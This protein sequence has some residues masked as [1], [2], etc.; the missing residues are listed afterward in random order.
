M[1]HNFLFVG[2]PSIP[3]KSTALLLPVFYQHIDPPSHRRTKQ[4]FKSVKICARTWKLCASQRKKERKKEREREAFVGFRFM[5][6]T[7]TC[8]GLGKEKK[9]EN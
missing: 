9:R 3:P 4:L 1:Q 7:S 8:L 5:Y 2:N 6:E